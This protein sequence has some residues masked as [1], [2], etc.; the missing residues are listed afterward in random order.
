[1][2]R[3]KGLELLYKNLPKNHTVDTVISASGIGFYGAVT[4][5]V[6]FT[7]DYPSGNDYIAD[8]CKKWEAALLPFKDI[9]I[10]TVSLRTAVVLSTKGGAL[11]KLCKV[12]RNHVGSVLGT[13]KQ[14]MPWVHI[15]DVCCAY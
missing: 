1:D 7:E 11:V 10:R 6:I 8:V 2:S 3:V 9:G 15:H 13:G 5:S 4:S 12:V 14:Y